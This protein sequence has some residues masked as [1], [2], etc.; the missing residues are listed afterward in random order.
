VTEPFLYPPCR[1][2]V[3]Y[4]AMWGYLSYKYRCT[5]ACTHAHTH[6]RVCTHYYNLVR[7]ND[8]HYDSSR[9]YNLLSEILFILFYIRCSINVSSCLSYDQT[10]ESLN[11]SL[12]TGYIWNMDHITFRW[13]IGACRLRNVITSLITAFRLRRTEVQQDWYPQSECHRNRTHI[14]KCEHLFHVWS[15]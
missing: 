5:H 6:M 3:R 14:R 9:N 1:L 7:L 4:I 10:L 8:S 13:T 12:C 15:V 11:P 2:Y